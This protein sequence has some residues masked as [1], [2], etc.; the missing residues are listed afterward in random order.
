VRADVFTG[1]AQEHR[2]P[3]LLWVD[4]RCMKNADGSSRLFTVGMSQFG[5]MELEIPAP[6]LSWG[7]LRIWT[8]NLA[9]H[10]IEQQLTI[11]DG[12]TVGISD[13]QRIRVSHSSS[14]VN[15]PGLVLRLSG[16]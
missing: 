7:E 9:A 1:M 11:G 3:V 8:M 2:V 14:F 5:L 10:L 15:R 12:E 13:Q 6:S 4:L 16:I